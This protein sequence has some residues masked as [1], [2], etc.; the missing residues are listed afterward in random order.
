[1]IGWHS[2]IGHKILQLLKST[3]FA[4]KDSNFKKILRKFL[5]SIEVLFSK[6]RIPIW[7][8][9]QKQGAIYGENL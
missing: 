5:E 3:H 1:M 7:F 2:L 9:K 4:I 6:K 8:L